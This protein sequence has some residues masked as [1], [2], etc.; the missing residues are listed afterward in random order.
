MDP[1]H[2]KCK[3]IGNSGKMGSAATCCSVDISIGI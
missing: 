1:T 2:A 3:V